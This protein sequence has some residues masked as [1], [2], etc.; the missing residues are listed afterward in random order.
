MS[1]KAKKESIYSTAENKR[2]LPSQAVLARHIYI[3][4]Y[5]YIQ[6]KSENTRK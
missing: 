4:I 1:S 2:Q 6:V 5:I 3:Y